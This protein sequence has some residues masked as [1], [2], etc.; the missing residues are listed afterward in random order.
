MD[1]PRYVFLFARSGLLL[2][3]NDP[4]FQ[5]PPNHQGATIYVNT[6]V[7]ISGL[8]EVKVGDFLDTEGDS[9][10]YYVVARPSKYIAYMDHAPN[11][12]YFPS[13]PVMS[14][15]MSSCPIRTDPDVRPYEPDDFHPPVNGVSCLIKSLAPG[16]L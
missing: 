6:S 2:P 3:E 16:N 8:E 1:D 10:I 13:I 5:C 11:E 4:P 7:H 12:E 15:V 14:A 9:G